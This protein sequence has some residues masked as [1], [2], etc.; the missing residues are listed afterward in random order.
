VSDEHEEQVAGVT[1]WFRR[2]GMHGVQTSDPTRKT[3][4]VILELDAAVADESLWKEVCQ[5]FRDGF[6]VFT[7]PDFHIEVMD[8]L[9]EKIVTL[10][11]RNKAL[12]L[13]LAREKDARQLL[14]KEYKAPL[15]AF[16]KTLRGRRA[17]P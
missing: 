8:I 15:E 7:A 14:E 1:L 9:R 17:G 11:D 16:S 6:R 13:E 2:E 12:E 10:E 5:K 4:T 3:R